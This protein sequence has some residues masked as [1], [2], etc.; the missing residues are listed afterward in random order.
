MTPKADFDM[1]KA[2]RYFAAECFNQAWDYIDKSTRTMEEDEQML[3]LTMASF[4]HWTQR[5]DCTPGNLSIG[6]WQL[7]RVH[8]LL[9]QA[10]PARHYGQLCLKHS[11]GESTEPFHLA[12]AYEALARAESVNGDAAKRDEYLRLAL[13]V[14]EALN[15]PETKKSLLADLSTI[16]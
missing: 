10:E 8:A 12:Y 16:S 14:G 3:M 15:D 9:R 13:E 4:W 7:S 2:H 11:R 6:Y 5:S 1:E